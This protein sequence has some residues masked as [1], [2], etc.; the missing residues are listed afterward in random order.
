MPR[1]LVLKAL[2]KVTDENVA[3]HCTVP[4]EFFNGGPTL[5]L[6]YL[7]PVHRR[8]HLRR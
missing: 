1:C 4:N 7:R 8:L 5:P 6:G 2:A 3:S